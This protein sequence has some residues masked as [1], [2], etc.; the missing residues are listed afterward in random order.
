VVQVC[1]VW[2]HAMANLTAT[3]GELLQYQRDQEWQLAGIPKRDIEMSRL[4][5]M[6]AADVRTFREYSASSHLLIVV[7]C[8]KEAARPWH[9]VF[10]PK[11][12]ATKAKSG[13]AGV[14]EDKHGR[15]LVSDYDL[16]SI[17][18]MVM[19]AAGAPVKVFMSAK[20]GAA[21][22]TW[23]DEARQIARDLNRRLV[24][25]IQHGCQDDFEN[26]QKNPGVSGTDRFIAFRLG[27][28]NFLPDVQACRQYY[29]QCGLRFPYGA[30]GEFQLPAG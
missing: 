16:M 3:L 22:G 7:R 26:L 17:W 14:A 15:L 25:R 12:I 11:N 27:A 9:G 24:S 2:E 23:S 4:A 20:D 18:R 29:R 21:R 30:R 5:G 13:V 8:P 19:G 28:V 10:P 1:T 6:H